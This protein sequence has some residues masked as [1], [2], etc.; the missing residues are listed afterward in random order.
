[1]EKPFGTGT[2][3][4]TQTAILECPNCKGLL[5]AG[6]DKKTRT[7]PYCNGKVDICKAKRLAKA[8]TAREASEIL[9]KLKAQRQE[10]PRNPEHKNKK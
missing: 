5:L 2:H 4:M 9:K 10:N 6:T 3:K 8:E 7:C 1:V